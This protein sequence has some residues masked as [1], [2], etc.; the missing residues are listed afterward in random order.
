MVIFSSDHTP[1]KDEEPQ[2]PSLLMDVSLTATGNGVI[3]A[4]NTKAQAKSPNDMKRSM[5]VRLVATEL[6][7]TT[8]QKTHHEA[9]Q[10]TD[11]LD[12]AVTGMDGQIPSHDLPAG[13]HRWVTHSSSRS[14]QKN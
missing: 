9:E 13:S 2:R 8:L 12:K 4:A 7:S 11:T 3:M 6:C 10:R 1:K 5:E 14:L